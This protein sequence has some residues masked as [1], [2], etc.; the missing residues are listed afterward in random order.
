MALVC[1]LFSSISQAQS[2]SALPGITEAVEATNEA[3]AAY[4]TCVALQATKYVEE[5]LQAT[6]AVDAATS[7][8]RKEADKHQS[9]LMRSFLDLGL[10]LKKAATK[11]NEIHRNRLEATRTAAIDLMLNTQAAQR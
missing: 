9:M 10:S 2:H 8:C 4:E 6:D 3:Y 7:K 11:T 5:G 1:I